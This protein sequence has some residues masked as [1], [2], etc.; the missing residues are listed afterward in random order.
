[1]LL[2]SVYCYGDMDEIMWD[3]DII[4][5]EYFVI[6]RDVL[7]EFLVWLILDVSDIDLFIV[8]MW[9]IKV[10]VMCFVVMLELFGDVFKFFM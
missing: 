9:C 5:Y 1:M 7:F 4:N 3:L 6:G 2:M 8:M 10:S